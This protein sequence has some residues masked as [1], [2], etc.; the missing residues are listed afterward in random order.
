MSRISLYIPLGVFAAILGLGYIG[1]DLGARN[2]LPSAL[3]NKPFRSSGPTPES[4]E[5]TLSRGSAGKTDF[6]QRLGNLVP[7][8]PERA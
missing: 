3:I 7:N 5:T 2:E 6:D 4:P 1:F 8:L